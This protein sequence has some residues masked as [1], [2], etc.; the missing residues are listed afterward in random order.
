MLFTLYTL[1]NKKNL[2]LIF[3]VV[4]TTTT[5][6]QNYNQLTDNGVY[7]QAG[8]NGNRGRSDSLQSK[9]KEIPR[10]LKV[11]T[12]D[13]RFGDRTMATPDTLSYMYMNKV[14]T[15]G[16]RSEYNS[17]GNLGA[18]RISRIIT[19][20]PESQ[21]F[22][23]TQ[24]YDYFITAPDKF[25]FTNTL[26]PITNLTYNNCGNRTNGED[27]FRALFAVNAGKR[28]GAGFL[29]NYIYGRGFYAN[30]STAHFNYSMFGSYLG[31][32]YQAHILFST[33][34]QKVTENGGITD[35]NYITHPETF[36]D[37]FRESEIPTVLEQNWNRNDNLH[38]FF[39]HRY[40]LGF[41]RKVKMTEDE[42][43]AKKFAI[44]SKKEN[45]EAKARER[46]RLRAKKSGANFD[47][48]T[49]DKQQAFSGRPDDAKISGDEPARTDTL[50]KK[51]R[52]VV[53]N[54]AMADSLIA[55]EKNN[56]QD[57]TWMKNEY[58]PVTSFIHTLKFDT[59][60]RIYQA[61]QT[62]EN[63]YASTYYNLG[64][65]TGDSIYDETRHYSIKNTFAIALLEGFNKWAK[66]G[67]KGFITSDLR[68][69]ELPDSTGGTN[70]FNEHNLSIGGQLS[71]TEGSI[72]H[73]NVTAETWLMGKD[74]GQLKIDATADLNF[75]L[76]GDTIQLAAKAF[77]YRLNPTFYFR[78]YHSRHFWWDN[79]NLDKQLHSHIEG[80]FSV[81]KTNTRLRIAVD[82]FE[83]Y[84]YLG[85]S[86]D[87]TESFTRINNTVNV[88]QSSANISLLTASLEQNFRLGIIHWDN[89][90]TYQKSSRQDILPAPDLNIY[91]NLYLRFKI[92][93]VLK[94]D[95]GADGRYFTKYF[96]PDYSP[97]LGQFTVQENNQKTEL[98][99]FPIIN[100]YANFNLQ[101]TRFFIMMSHVNAG[102]GNKAYF[103]T[104]HYPLNG[105]VLRFGLSWNFFN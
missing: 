22:V 52:I 56:E 31:D 9:N 47:E 90:V 8:S 95:M 100:V 104:P 41:N 10:G 81:K 102:S 50:S 67:L 44:Q 97:A 40:S 79:E 61:Y 24:P 69:F 74:A 76:F 19:D 17:T 78:H 83:K 18:P 43:K 85:Q 25:Q 27:Y 1:M 11:W 91:T 89:V 72:L 53:K 54:Q 49:F 98:G 34:H 23:F 99:N 96:A 93:K 94:V 21:Q 59:Y 30:Q 71:K 55:I 16:L 20:R 80:I 7:T 88:R 28:I 64:K 51:E 5:L 86:Y 70:M 37:N 12:V 6:A 101:H 87:I 58:L 14:F 66:A 68:H 29:F 4:A 84:T 105:S 73:Y 45:Q 92:A 62:P 3:F 77:F 2:I 39:T 82:N 15:T 33:N 42:I 32:R 35:D 60:H 38:I 103:Y 48:E 13:E 46:A 26:S 65:L 57:T 63:F 75:K 36:N